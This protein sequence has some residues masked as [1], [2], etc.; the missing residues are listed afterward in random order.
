MF[1]REI[2]LKEISSIEQ[3]IIQYRRTV[4]AFAETGGQEFK[5][6]A[7]IQEKLTEFGIPFEQLE[8]TGLIG[9]IDTGKEGPHIGLRAD[10]D[11]LPMPEEETNLKNPRVCMSD[12]PDKTCHACGHDAHTAMLLGAARILAA[13]KEDLKGIIY[14][15]FD[16]KGEM[17]VQEEEVIEQA[18]F[19]IDALPD[20]LS[21]GTIEVV[22]KAREYLAKETK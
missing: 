17:K 12:T 1:T 9:T 3:D 18:F 22:E 16:F 6:S 10:I 20:N 15:C 14:I 5:T 7:F 19:P 8:G 13:H 4:H 21:P 2:L 11:A